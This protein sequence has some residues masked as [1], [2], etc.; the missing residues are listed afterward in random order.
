M[1]V[2]WSVLITCL[3]VCELI[4]KRASWLGK[5]NLIES[6]H[7]VELISQKAGWVGKAD[8]LQSLHLL[9]VFVYLILVLASPDWHLVAALVVCLA[10]LDV[11]HSMSYLLFGKWSSLGLYITMLLEVND[12]W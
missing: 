10:W 3:E 5:V 2:V 4:T 7:L 9:L 6:P 12:P 11:S 1:P 8:L